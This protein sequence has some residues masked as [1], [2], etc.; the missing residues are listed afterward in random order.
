MLYDIL[1][2]SYMLALRCPQATISQ[3]RDIKHVLALYNA[4]RRWWI[5]LI[6]AA[7]YML[8]LRCPQAIS[9]IPRHPTCWL[10]MTPTGDG[11]SPFV[12]VLRIFARMGDTRRHF[13]CYN[14][15]NS[16]RVFLRFLYFKAQS[17]IDSRSTSYTYTSLDTYDYS[18]EDG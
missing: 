12:H 9:T 8:A 3:F 16:T 5:P 15:K 13:F 7:S 17:Y 1:A 14:A 4:H 2:A 10:S 18:C 6:L 11:G